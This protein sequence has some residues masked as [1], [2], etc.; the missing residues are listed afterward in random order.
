MFSPSSTLHSYQKGM[1]ISTVL[2]LYN[3]WSSYAVEEEGVVIAYTSVYGNTKQAVEQLAEGLL[4][5][6]LPDLQRSKQALQELT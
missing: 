5:H 6:Y 3:I 4:S 2:D 1:K